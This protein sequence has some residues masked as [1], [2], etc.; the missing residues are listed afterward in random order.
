M[1]ARFDGMRCSFLVPGDLNAHTGGYTYDRHIIEALRASGWQVEVH[2]LGDGFPSPAAEALA[3]TA[4]VVEALPDGALAVV[5]G[6]AFGVL[7][8]LAHRH[9]QRLRWVA[10]VHHPLS[11][12]TG[13]DPA[14]QRALY[15]SER[16]ALAAVRGVIVTSPFTARG[17]DA[18]GVPPSRVAVVVPGTEAAPPATGSGGEGLSLLCVATLTP[19]K[20]HALLVEAL[21]SLQDR[22]WTLHCVGSKT[23]DAACASALCDAIDK[24]GLRE[25]I[26]LHGDKAEGE[27]PAFYAAADAFVLPSFHEGYGMALAEALARGLPVISTRAGAIPDTVPTEAGELVPAGDVVALRTALLRLMEDPAWRAQLRAGAMAARRAL[28]TWRQSGARFATALV[29]AMQRPHAT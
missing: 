25:R 16:R 4:R 20:G 13:L 9:A 23:M 26:V 11:L 27:L 22:A 19:R 15:E 8:E 18:F 24:R 2:A 28:P 10:L 17:L 29:D 1:S 5:D 6:L 12:E 21:A 14:R 3:R 7:D